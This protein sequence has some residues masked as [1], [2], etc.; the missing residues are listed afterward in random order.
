LT[1]KA[2]SQV[3]SSSGSRSPQK[4]DD[5]GEAGGRVD[6]WAPEWIRGWALDSG[7]LLFCQL[8]AIAATSLLAIL[9]ARNLTPHEW[10]VFSGFLALGLALA[11]FGEFGMSTWLLR[12]LTVLLPSDAGKPD[13]ETWS[14]AGVL[15]SSSLML[16]LSIA[17]SFVIVTAVA[18]LF[19]S[20]DL[21]L[22]VAVIALVAYGGIISAS[23]VPEAFFRSR[24]HLRR[25]VGATLV[26]K[27]LL[28]ALVAACVAT[29][30]GVVVIALVYVVAGLTRLAFNLANT[31]FRDRLRLS[32]SGFGGMTTIFRRS[33]PFGANRAFLNVIPRADAFL[34]AI[35]SAVAAGYFALGDRVIG[36]ALIIPVVASRAL[37]PFLGREG[38][39]K[40]GL[41]VVFLFASGG[42]VAAAIGILI[43]PFAVPL[44]FGSA[45]RPAVPVVQ[46]MILVVP[47][48][49]VSNPLLVHLYSGRREGRRLTIVLAV[50]TVAGTGAI[51]S[52]QLLIGTTAAAAGYVL[53]QALFVAA[54]SIAALAPDKL[55]KK[56][57]VT[58]SPATRSLS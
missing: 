57:R 34:L 19:L 23:T 45:F 58:V 35:I 20:L 1:L 24:R 21:G 4:T 47:F 41:K 43:A 30:S 39:A 51:V 32:W 46:I 50:I 52:G 11:V 7:V 40:S 13:P 48:V 12:E 17:G 9:I 27:F 18:V 49:F 2:D 14:R 26:E 22:A 53:R 44:L 42:V 31:V 25:I 8:A 55:A 10:G 28:L 3:R 33:L 56:A 15:V 5:G 54:L 16:S 6:G 37:Y 38:N 29:G 36:P